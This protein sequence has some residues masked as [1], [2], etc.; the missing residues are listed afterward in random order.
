MKLYNMKLRVISVQYSSLTI[1]STPHLLINIVNR[2]YPLYEIESG[3]NHMSLISG[4]AP[5]AQGSFSSAETWQSY[6]GF[7]YKLRV[8]F[9]DAFI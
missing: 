8:I 2:D 1:K 4:I 5:T 3:L 7:P 6:E 9:N